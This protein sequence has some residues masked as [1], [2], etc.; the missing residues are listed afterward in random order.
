MPNNRLPKLS[1]LPKITVGHPTGLLIAIILLGLI[2]IFKGVFGCLIRILIRL[3]FNLTTP[4]KIFE[5]EIC[6]PNKIFKIKIGEWILNL[7]Q[8][9]WFIWAVLILGLIIFL[10]FK[11]VKEE[12]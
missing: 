10:Y 7:F 12:K 4:E 2:L 8:H 3:P 5:G 9:E 6:N 11:F 1:E